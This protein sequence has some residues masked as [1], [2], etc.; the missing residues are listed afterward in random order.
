M[1]RKCDCPK[2]ED[3]RDGGKLEIRLRK[4]EGIMIKS[5]ISPLFYHYPLN[6]LRCTE[7]LSFINSSCFISSNSQS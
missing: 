7:Q 2:S 6:P 4:K 3:G 1:E 5:F